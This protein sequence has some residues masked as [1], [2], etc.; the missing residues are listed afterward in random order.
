MQN[1]AGIALSW[2]VT[3]IDPKCAPIES[4]HLFLFHESSNHRTVSQWKKI[5]EIKALPLPMACSLS[6]F[7][8][9][10]KYYFTIQAKDVCG[11]YGPF[12]D[13]QSITLLP[14]ETSTKDL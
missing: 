10:K 13:I 14:L 3:E 8:V 6:Q 4:Y 11:R 1:P 9:L 2:T 5:G 7:T 12:C